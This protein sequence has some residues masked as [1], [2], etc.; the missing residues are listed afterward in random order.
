M[1]AVAPHQLGGHPRPDQFL[2]GNG[3]VPGAHTVVVDRAPAA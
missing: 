3:P 2:A 1:L